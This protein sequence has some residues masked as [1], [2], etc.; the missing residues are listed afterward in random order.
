MPL[1]T[2]TPE[3]IESLAFQL[4]N[5]AASLCHRTWDQLE[6]V[7]RMIQK[8]GKAKLLEALGD[9]AK[10]VVEAVNAAK[11]LLRMVRSDVSEDL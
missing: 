5:Q 1:N 2:P 11:K 4:K 3:P 8:T 7:D 9:D 6:H 10:E